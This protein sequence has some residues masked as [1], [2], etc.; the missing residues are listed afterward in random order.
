MFIS[1]LLILLILL[2]GRDKF[3]LLADYVNRVGRDIGSFI[4]LLWP[5]TKN[6]L[7]TTSRTCIPNKPN[8]PTVAS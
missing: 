8:V 2:V 7:N 3:Q 5:Y 4:G 1:S 6:G